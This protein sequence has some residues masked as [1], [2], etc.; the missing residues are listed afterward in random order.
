MGA[1]SIRSLLYGYSVGHG[2]SLDM[3]AQDLGAFFG[4][5]AIFTKYLVRQE[6]YDIMAHP[7]TIQILKA[8]Q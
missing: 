8:D 6:S 4:V 3:S 7:S 5:L 2:V 1:T